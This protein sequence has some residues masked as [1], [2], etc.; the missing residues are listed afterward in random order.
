MERQ[1]ASA[2]TPLNPNPTS[3]RPSG[4][5]RLTSGLGWDYFARVNLNLELALET[6]RLRSAAVGF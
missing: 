2:A 1:V 6:L 5:K 3:A 4:K